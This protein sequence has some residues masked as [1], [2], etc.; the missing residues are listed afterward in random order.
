MTTTAHWLH[1]RLGHPLVEVELDEIAP[2]QEPQCSEADIIAR[3]KAFAAA[4]LAVQ[5]VGR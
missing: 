1:L 4:P 2:L 3:Q 5:F